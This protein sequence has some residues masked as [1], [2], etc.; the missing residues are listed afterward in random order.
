LQSLFLTDRF[1]FLSGEKSTT[2]FAEVLIFMGTELKF[3]YNP[4]QAQEYLLM[5]LKNKNIFPSHNL[6][7]QATITKQ[8]TIP[9][10]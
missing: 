4:L 9:E 10:Q 5:N 7:Y 1:E 2:F 6:G 3:C 8:R